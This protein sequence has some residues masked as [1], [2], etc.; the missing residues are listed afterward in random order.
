MSLF[1]SVRSG[2]FQASTDSDIFSLFRLVL[3]TA[4]QW[5]EKMSNSCCWL[6]CLRNSRAKMWKMCGCFTRKKKSAREIVRK[7]LSTIACDIVCVHLN[8][9]FLLVWLGFSCAIIA[10]TWYCCERRLSTKRSKM[11]MLSC[12]TRWMWVRNYLLFSRYPPK[13]TYTWCDV[14]AQPQQWAN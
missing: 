1:C 10:F 8:I 4:M 6:A 3:S 12:C 11:T 7:L 14:C 13:F 2:F 9:D 5:T